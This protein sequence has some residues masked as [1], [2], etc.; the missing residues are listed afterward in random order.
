VQLTFCGGAGRV[1]GSCFLFE[2]E[3]TRFLVDCGMF[4][5]PRET[6]ALNVAPFPFDPSAIDFVILTHAHLDHGGLLPRLAAQGFSGPVYATPATRDLLAVMLPD[7]AYVMNAE[8]ARAA[9]TGRRYEVPYGLDDAR[10]VLRQVESVPYGHAFAPAPGV[11]AT[12]QDAGHILGSSFVTLRLTERQRSVSVVVSGDLGQPGRP[13]VRDPEPRPESDILLLESTYGDR[14]HPP[15]E[16]TLDELAAVLQ[17]ALEASQGI[18]LVPAFAVGR[19]QDLLYHLHRMVQAGRIRSIQAFVD[20]PMAGEVTRIT[21]RYFE[22]FDDEARRTVK[23]AAA[24]GSGLR[25]SYTASVEESKALN[26]LTGGAIILA[27][28]GMCDGGRIR[29]HLRQRLPDPRTTV[30][31]IG[32]Q[33]AGTLGRRLVDGSPV[34]RIFGQEVP[35]R[36]KIARLDGFS[37]HADRAALL[38]WLRGTRRPPGRTYL[39]HGEPAASAALANEISG[40][41]GWH[42]E[43]AGHGQT[44]T[45]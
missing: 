17:S 37:A 38:A 33:A 32:Y 4:Q 20:S 34:V 19:T 5:G 39:V 25:V 23:E 31:F 45:L 22:L 44:V 41:P 8:A 3:A 18:V 27:A 2:V 1:T 12:L 7:S 35:V 10:A 16:R 43:V 26:R 30:L 9:K 15:M 42:C 29:H 24:T 6:W 11:A 14:D 13:I 36:A 28:S 40:A 21:A